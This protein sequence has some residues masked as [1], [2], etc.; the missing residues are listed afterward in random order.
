MGMEK[1]GA[2]SNTP[3]KMSARPS[4]G[5]RGIDKITLKHIFPRELVA[6]FI[7]STMSNRTT[8]FSAGFT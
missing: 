1:Q 2:T 3:S 7:S 6:L 8:T 5:A 4:S